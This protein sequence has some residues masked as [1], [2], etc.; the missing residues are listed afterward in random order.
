MGLLGLLA[1][2][3]D[4]NPDPTPWQGNN[5]YDV[6]VEDSNLNRLAVLKT[7]LPSE[8]EEVL[9]DQGH[10]AMTYSAHDP[11]IA[12]LQDTDGS[13]L[14]LQ[15]SITTY[16]NGVPVMR[17]PL[18]DWE[19]APNGDITP[20]LP[21]QWWWFLAK[22][23]FGRANNPSFLPDDHWVWPSGSH[24]TNWENANC[25][26]VRE[27]NELG[28]G[29][30]VR[31]PA[32]VDYGPGAFIRTLDYLTPVGFSGGLPY[33]LTVYFKLDRNFDGS[34]ATF[35]DGRVIE[36][37]LYQ[38]YAHLLAEDQWDYAWADV[39]DASPPDLN[40]WQEIHCVIV[41]PNSTVM[42]TPLLDI[43]LMAGTDGDVK[44]A[45]APF[46]PTL[47]R[48]ETFASFESGNDVATLAQWAVQYAQDPLN[49]KSDLHIGTDCATGYAGTIGL[50]EP[51]NQ[52]RMV[53]ELIQKELCAID[54]G[55][56][57]RFDYTPTT[58]TFTTGREEGARFQYHQSDL[59][60]RQG[61]G[62]LSILVKR[63]GSEASTDVIERGSNTGFYCYAGS[64][65]DRSGTGGIVLDEVSQ[66]AAGTLPGNLNFIAKRR[67]DLLKVPAYEIEAVLPAEYWLDGPSSRIGGGRAVRCGDTF[68]SQHF[69]GS[70]NA[71]PG[72]HRVSR[73]K[74]NPAQDTMTVTLQPIDFGRDLADDL[75]G[76]RRRQ[77]TQ[78]RKPS[79]AAGNRVA[80][81]PVSVVLPFTGDGSGAVHWTAGVPGVARANGTYVVMGTPGTWEGSITSSALSSAGIVTVPGGCLLVWYSITGADLNFMLQVNRPGAAFQFVNS[82]AS[83]GHLTLVL[84]QPSKITL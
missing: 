51:L 56:D 28:P 3:P 38:D 35:F 41:I 18:V 79:L 26:P 6:V 17:S 31:I 59:P 15:R 74:L 67:L 29:Y 78:E 50:S 27:A 61:R 24:P 60:L 11:A 9:N 84:V 40:G 42:P 53:G 63:K 19:L 58:T 33:V 81:A 25:A 30:Q 23:F 72:V 76:L 34:P 54:G 52:H 2:T 75:S 37:F 70:V 71:C 8:I 1:P 80:V 20:Q 48:D 45:G 14:V 10:Q 39:V 69:V 68:D 49:G 62:W 46:Y 16:M 44:Y 77:S 82:A 55:V 43:H 32:P 83:H 5:R 66:A 73:R 64:A 47:T 36:V 7:A 21:D 12:T 57:C 4:P 13:L 22:R 65:S